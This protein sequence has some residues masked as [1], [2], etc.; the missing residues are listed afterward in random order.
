MDGFEARQGKSAK[1]EK[2][3]G[4]AILITSPKMSLANG[5]NFGVDG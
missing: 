3:G 2:V 4:V 5:V 1:F